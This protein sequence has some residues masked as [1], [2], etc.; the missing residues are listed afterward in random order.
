MIREEREE[1]HEFVTPEGAASIV[2]H[3]L[4][5]MVDLGSRSTEKQ[6]GGINVEVFEEIEKELEKAQL[7]RPNW[8]PKEGDTLLG[9]IVR[10]DHIKTEKI[11]NDLMEIKPSDGSGEV[12]VWKSQLLKELFEKAKLGDN[13]GL[14]YLGKIKSDAGRTY[15][16]IRWVLKPARG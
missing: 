11:D 7:T 4:G 10:I 16:N 6:M 12:T 9:V 15:K 5:V 1:L 14:K 8:E 2:A 13:V 3:R